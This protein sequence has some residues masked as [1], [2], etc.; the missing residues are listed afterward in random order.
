V[1]PSP[2]QAPSRATRAYAS[3][4]LVRFLAHATLV[5]GVILAVAEIASAVGAATQSPAWVTV[6]V[7]VGDHQQL[8]M[9]LSSAE[10]DDRAVVLPAPN[11]VP[12]M[13]NAVRFDI[14][15]VEPDTWIDSSLDDVALNAWNS[16]RIEQFLSRGDRA[17]IGLCVG[18]GVFWLRRLLLSIAEGEPF[19]SGNPARIAGLAALVAVGGLGADVLPYTAA[20]LVLSRIGLTA[21]DAPIT[22]TQ[23]PF[24]VMPLLLAGMLLALAEAFRR[25]GE[26]AR[27]VDGL[28]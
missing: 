13:E 20:S 15:G 22:A 28:V 26:L 25:G 5:L 1:D 3:T 17:L 9:P 24:D 12:L 21:A 6:R 18:I 10:G 8:R 23:H 19:R 7:D 11:G 16:T 14:R 2:P 27:D 4:R